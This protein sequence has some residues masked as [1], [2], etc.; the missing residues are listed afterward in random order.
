M[1]WPS[2]LPSQLGETNFCGSS[3][4]P[5]QHLTRTWQKRLGEGVW[6]SASVRL[7]S[8]RKEEDYPHRLQQVKRVQRIWAGA[9]LSFLRIHAP[10]PWIIC[11]LILITWTLP[12]PTILSYR[13]NPTYTLPP[14]H[15]VP[16]RRGLHEK[17]LQLGPV[18]YR[19]VHFGQGGDIKPEGH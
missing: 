8:Q 16:G 5:P 18:L 15:S 6:T 1:P 19:K 9:N 17:H 14:S 10:L 13:S 7:L 3:A 11:I 12:A 2:S 4:Q